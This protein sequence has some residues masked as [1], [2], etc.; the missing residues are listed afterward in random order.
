MWN[1]ISAEFGKS[2][3]SV[4]QRMYEELMDAYLSSQYNQDGHGAT[5]FA[6]FVREL[7]LSGQVPC[8]AVLQAGFL[9]MVL[10]MYLHDFLPSGVN[11]SEVG[12]MF[13]RSSLVAACNETLGVFAA[14]VNSDVLVEHPVYVLW[15]KSFRIQ[16]QYIE[17]RQVWRSLERSLVL[18]R[19]GTILNVIFL[20]S[21]STVTTNDSVDALGDLFEFARQVL[22]LW[23]KLFDIYVCMF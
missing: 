10:C 22:L 14:S 17:R 21:D 19:L 5:P 11:H 2:L 7:A 9:S 15:A 16:E 20:S 1:D 23:I 6:N 18:W 3:E 12:W 4:R 13:R 8:Q